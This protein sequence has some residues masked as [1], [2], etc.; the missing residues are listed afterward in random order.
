MGLHLNDTQ[1]SDVGLAHFKDCKEL[2][3]LY[4]KNTR[5]SDAGVAPF[6]DC[7]NMTILLLQKTKVTAAGVADFAKGLPGC[8][9]EWDGG[10]IEPAKK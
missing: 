7:K 9:I 4:L 6:K 2:R 10:V 8:K 1:V 5:V 3:W